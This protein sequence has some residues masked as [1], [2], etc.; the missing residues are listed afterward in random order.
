MQVTFTVSPSKARPVSTQRSSRSG[1]TGFSD[2][3][4][5][6]GTSQ[7]MPAPLSSQTVQPQKVASR[8]GKI[9]PQAFSSRPVTFSSPPAHESSAVKRPPTTFC[10]HLPDGV[11]GGAHKRPGILEP[12]QEFRSTAPDY[13]GMKLQHSIRTG[14]SGHE[15][16][17]PP[18]EMLL[19][20]H[21]GHD[22][23]SPRSRNMMT[24][25]I[26]HLPPVCHAF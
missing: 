7:K 24:D 15:A 2:E 12:P 14:L 22:V 3:G 17:A 13:H 11:R 23:C 16:V 18:C 4:D 26:P 21:A 20:Q 25:V 1:E 19:L 10:N 9:Q 6:T 5:V 8:Q